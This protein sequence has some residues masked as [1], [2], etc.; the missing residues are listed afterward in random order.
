[1]DEL[2]FEVGDAQF[3]ARLSLCERVNVSLE[4]TN[5]GANRSELL[6]DTRE[7][8]LGADLAPIRTWDGDEPSDGEFRREVDRALG[9][10][11]ALAYG[12]QGDAFGVVVRTRYPLSVVRERLAGIRWLDFVSA[13][14]TGSH[15][16]VTLRRVRPRVIQV[17]AEGVPS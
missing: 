1:L 16:E 11:G 13:I 4:R 7:S 2:P 9:T 14:R 6:L 10:L 17:P 3:G 15:W 5:V 8:R 12:P